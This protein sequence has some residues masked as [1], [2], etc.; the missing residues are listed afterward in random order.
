[1]SKCKYCEKEVPSKSMGAH[2]LSC[3]KNPKYQEFID[4]RNKTKHEKLEVL[5]TKICYCEK[6]QNEFT[7]DIT[8]TKFKKK[9]HFFC[10]R[11]CSNSRTRSEETKK[12]ISLGN[13]KPA[14]ISK[15]KAC[16]NDIS[17]RKKYCNKTCMFKSRIPINRSYR[18]A[19][20]FRFNVFDFP[21]KF[22]LSLIE[23]H[24]WYYPTNS[25]RNKPNLNGVSKDHRFSVSD[26]ERLNINPSIIAHPANCELMLHT[27]NI[28]KNKSSS[29]TY[30][31]LLVEIQIWETEHSS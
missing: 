26:A 5:V 15:C 22:D 8:E 14:K 9:K 30:D 13:S 1:M 21:N 11:A 25:K 18:Y 10:S 20:Q 6:C 24:G 12:L 4:K 3:N 2:V 19:C 7:L 31:D 23:K 16:G 17:S 28:S 29:I 27:E